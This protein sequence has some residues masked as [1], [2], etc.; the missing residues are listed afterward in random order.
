M[1]VNN[2]RLL[3]DDIINPLRTLAYKIFNAKENSKESEVIYEID[4]LVN[5]KYQYSVK[6]FRY[7]EYTE[8]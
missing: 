4:L 5:N 3:I 6:T 7:E 8:I 2:E 1:G